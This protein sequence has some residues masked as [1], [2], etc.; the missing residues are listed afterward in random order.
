MLFFL[1]S[2]SLYVAGNKKINVSLNKLFHTSIN[3][4]IRGG[5]KSFMLDLGIN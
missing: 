2:N 3:G 4:I 1:M 5:G